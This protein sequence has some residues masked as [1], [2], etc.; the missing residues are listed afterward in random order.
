[1]ASSID[2]STPLAGTSGL[3]TTGTPGT[4][5]TSNDDAKIIDLLKQIKQGIPDA[6]L[7][8]E[9]IIMN[10]TEPA[11]QTVSRDASG[12]FRTVT[13]TSDNLD[14]IHA[15]TGVP[16]KEGSTLKYF[17]E[18]LASGD[19]S[20]MET[21]LETMN[22]NDF[23]GLDQQV[24]DMHPIVALRT[25]QKFG[26]RKHKVYVAEIG[27]ELWRV[28]SADHWRNNY[29]KK[30]FTIDK[31]RKMFD[32]KT[33]HI[34]MYLD[35]ISGYVNSNPAILN[36]GYS[37]VA[38]SPLQAPAYLSKFGSTIILRRDK[39]HGVT[40]ASDLRR[41]V[42]ALQ[43]APA[44]SPY[45]MPF[46]G[47]SPKSA[48]N[49]VFPENFTKFGAT[50][51]GGDP[52]N[53]SCDNKPLLGSKFIADLLQSQLASLK[54]AGYVVSSATEKAI[55]DQINSAKQSETE[56]GKTVC[57]IGR[58]EQLKRQNAGKNLSVFNGDLE[59][60]LIGRHLKLATRLR[61]TEVDLG[62]LLVKL[63]E[64]AGGYSKI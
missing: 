50:Q 64:S 16:K 56:L 19:A 57:M 14:D 35:R 29:L 42:T 48:Y 52:Y 43:L 41:L 40:D 10:V 25:L 27:Q 22:D 13:V 60:Q 6:D 18:C 9:E 26:F 4:T 61:S 17:Q 7:G 34:F 53:F 24:S 38:P 51:S 37:G 55:N 54:D 11:K 44:F 28:E 2:S 58:F 47:G 46:V 49:G 1:M 23:D 36:K 39:P 63:I 33:F 31:V 20:S 32:H 15:Q 8:G 3:T 21:C 5:G 62:N 30:H 59:S 12:D 45:A